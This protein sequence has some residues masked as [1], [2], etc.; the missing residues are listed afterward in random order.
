MLFDNINFLLQ[1]RG[2]LP[3]FGEEFVNIKPDELWEL[4]SGL[5]YP[6]EVL[7]TVDLAKREELLSKTKI[8]LVVLDVDGVMT[9]G[10][11]HYSSDGRDYKTFNVKDGMGI[12]RAIKQ[13]VKFAII[14]ASS[15]S[16][17]IKMRAKVLGI[18][19]VYVTKEPKLQVLESLLYSQGLG[20]EQ[21]AYIGDDINDVET[22]KKVGIGAAPSDAMPEAKIAADIILNILN[23]PG[24][25]GCVREFLDFYSSTG[26]LTWVS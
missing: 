7:N 21:V 18:Q 10:G 24:G 14:S 22:L 4:V 23:T 5:N 2:A 1:K 6:F 12:T 9:D 16:E 8:Q 17:V 20:F 26:T 3:L 11:L 13:G 15:H 19:H 25:R